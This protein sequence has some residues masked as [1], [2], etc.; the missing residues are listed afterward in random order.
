M[1]KKMKNNLNLLINNE[2]LFKIYFIYNSNMNN[3][4]ATK[5]LTSDTEYKKTGKSLQQTLSPN[6]I[7]EKLEEYVKLDSIDEAPLN[8][9]IR[10][11]TID[12]KTNKKQFRL[13]GFLT[14]IDTAYVV[15]SN[16]RLS[17]SVQKTNTDF[18]K[19]MSYTEL[20][21]ELIDKISNKFEKKLFSLE[22]EN[23]ALKTTLK[24]IK[25][26]IKK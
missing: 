4:I 18:F 26:T 21:E 22:K 25:R 23:I 8:S 15:L 10:Y 9:H 5:R 14:K 11:F 7:K 6:E 17:W 24:D 3:F 2:R 1:K 20:K 13:G 12:K 16:G 19:K